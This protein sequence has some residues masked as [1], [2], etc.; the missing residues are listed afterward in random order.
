MKKHMSRKKK[1]IRIVALLSALLLFGL[2]GCSGRSAQGSGG[3]TVEEMMETDG[4]AQKVYYNGVWYQEKEDIESYLIMGVDRSGEAVSSGSYNGGGQADV[5]MVLVID[6]DQKA[7]HVL[8]INRDTMTQVDVLGM[9][10]DKVG[11]EVQ[12][13]ALAHFYGDGLEESCENTVTA[14]SNLL[15]GVKLDGYAAIQMDAIP[16]INDWA[17]GVTVTIQDDFS[18]SDSSLVMGETITLTGEQAYSFLRY[19]VDVGDGT[20]EARMARH[21]QYFAAFS[22]KMS[23]RL[24]EDLGAIAELYTEIQPYMVTDMGSGTVSKI[25]QKCKGY[26]N[27]GIV[28]MEGESKLGEKYMEFYP[29]EDSIKQAVFQLFYTEVQEEA[30]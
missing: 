12:Q 22:E 3:K 29:D 24:D 13:I 21:R 25:A 11:T 7:Y 6:H 8:Q 19:R 10:G 28:T 18:Q 20:N 4:E 23:Q 26:T 15:Y 5:L 1:Y 14:V 30:K 27:G 17:G 16:Y 9:F 2:T